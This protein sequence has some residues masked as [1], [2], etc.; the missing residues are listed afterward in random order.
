MS[1]GRRNL[2]LFAELF[3]MVCAA[4]IWSPNT[5]ARASDAAGTP[6]PGLQQPTSETSLVVRGRVIQTES[7][8]NSDHSLIESRSTLAVESNLSGT[9][10]ANPGQQ[11]AQQVTVYT[12]GGEL[13]DGMGMLVSDAPMLQPGEEVELSLRRSAQDLNGY[14]IAG[15]SSARQYVYNNYKWPTT[16]VR[17]F[18][19]ANT[20]QAGGDN[21][22]QDD[23]LA[24]IRRA[25][26]TWTYAAEADITF[27]YA[28]STASTK[29]GFN[30]A[31]EIVFVNDGLVDGAGN[32]RPLATAL[33]FY[34]KSTIVETDIKIND[35]YTWYAAGSLSTAEF[36]LQ[37]VVL[38]ELGHWLGL[39]HDE[40][41]QAVMYAQ[42][43]TG[44]VKRALFENDLQ[45]IAALYPCAAGATCNPEAPAEP[46]FIPD[47]ILASTPG[48]ANDPAT[49]QPA[50]P[51]QDLFLPL[52][53]S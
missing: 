40:D 2:V 45:G 47:P 36:D 49:Q 20:Q 32:N 12:M 38:H 50:V 9:L 53:Q 42:M 13:P 17:F 11:S 31:N 41:D 52:V 46:S 16:A 43:A 7:Y 44:I 30:G 10:A 18:V 39:G 25:A 3:I 14:E 48:A 19:N 51:S 29:V 4:V 5:V 34:M 26:N 33:V 15:S 8:W 1:S 21:G 35:A 37:S 22:S 28:G 24:A 27:T 6:A 23:F